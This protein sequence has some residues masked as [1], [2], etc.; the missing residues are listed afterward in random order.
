MQ[1]SLLPPESRDKD[2]MEKFNTL[3][4]YAALRLLGNRF[5]KACLVMI[6]VC[7]LSAHFGN[8]KARN[9]QYLE[10]LI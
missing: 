10:L 5:Q 1:I 9:A 7:P 8:S 6:A 3:L 2:G 4:V